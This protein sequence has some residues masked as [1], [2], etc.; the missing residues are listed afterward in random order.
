[1]ALDL[2]HPGGEEVTFDTEKLDLSS[3]V[4]RP[5][6]VYSEQFPGKPLKTRIIECSGQTISLDRGGAERNVDNLVNN[7]RVTIKF[8]YK[9]QTIT[10]EALLKRHGGGKCRVMM[11]E[12]A[13]P[14]VRRRFYRAKLNLIA[15]LA[16]LHAPSFHASKLKKL[17]WIEAESADI[18]G[19]GIL[20]DLTSRLEADTKLFV[21]VEHDKFEF[22][23]LML[24]TVRH[25]SQPVTGHF[26]TGVEFLT[27]ESAREA[28]PEATLAALPKTVLQFTSQLRA[29]LN[30]QLISWTKDNHLI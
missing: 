18:S 2:I 14:L 27:P 13:I 22:P 16:V 26:Y 10:A 8:E 24:G 3:L 17:R 19:G 6:V 29:E 9:G 1:M 25:C 11:G 28:V 20:L 23:A 21:S 7:Q 12:K 4:G 30:R 5:I 15:R